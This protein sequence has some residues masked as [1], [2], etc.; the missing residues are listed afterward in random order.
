MKNLVFLIVILFNLGMQ[1][2]SMETNPEVKVSEIALEWHF[3]AMGDSR[4]W[5]VLTVNPLRASIMNEV[6]E[7]NPNLEF[8]LHSG[9][10]VNQ[11]GDQ[12]EWDLWFED[13]EN[14]TLNNVTIYSAIGNHEI[15]AVD[16]PDD[17]DFSTY[18]EN[19]NLPG[20]ERFYSFNYN[21]IHFI[22]LNTEENWNGQFEMTTEQREWLI[23][24]LENNRLDFIVGLYHRP[25][26]SVRSVARQNDAKE[27]REV[28][29]PI[30]IDYGVD[31][32][33]AGHDHQYYRTFRDGVMHVTTGGA[34]A[35]LYPKDTNSEWQE[36]DV[37]FSN[38][39][40][41]NVSVTEYM[42][43]SVSLQLD[44]YIYYEE[45]Q[46]ISLGDSFQLPMNYVPSATTTT[47]TSTTSTMTTSVI[48]IFPVLTIVAGL[49]II[50]II[51]KMER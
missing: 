25:C 33:F 38:Y 39:H 41:I 21:K 44:M 43:E 13:I 48:T 29:Q 30:F 49:T 40:Y 28:L 32:V 50:S 31:L 17:Q 22:I 26:F 36:G 15:Y 27:I 4:N 5:E 24:D 11:G 23:T 51:K 42:N 16:G 7:A 12:R 35:P 8:I 3:I 47:I 45:N 20:N 46:S 34:G 6:V 1:F 19:V 18:M 14:A 2:S 37:F 10:L 9:D